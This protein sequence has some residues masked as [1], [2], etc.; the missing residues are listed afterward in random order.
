M[1]E[2]HVTDSRRVESFVLHVFDN[3][4]G[5]HSGAD[6]DQRKLASAIDEI[7]M[8]VKRVG[9]IETTAARS[10]QVHALGQSHGISKLKL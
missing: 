8:T 5:A 1:G 3:P 7:D 6:I 4:C 2:N 10:D 9:H